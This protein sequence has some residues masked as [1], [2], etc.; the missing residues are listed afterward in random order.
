[1]SLKTVGL[2][3]LMGQSGFHIPARDRSELAVFRQVYADIGDEQSI[4]Q[5]SSTFLLPHDKYRF[6]PA[7]CG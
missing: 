3:T 6:F 4:E 2:F 1:M 5:S 7:G